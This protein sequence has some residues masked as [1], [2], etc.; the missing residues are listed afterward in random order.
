MVDDNKDI[1]EKMLDKATTS[2]EDFIQS[3]SE[4]KILQ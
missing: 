4:D 3:S 2:I 1:Y